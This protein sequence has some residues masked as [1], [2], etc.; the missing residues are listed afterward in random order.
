MSI[1]G[2]QADEKTF[3]EVA[4]TNCPQCDAETVP[5]DRFC[6]D[7]GILLN[8]RHSGNTEPRYFAFLSSLD[9]WYGASKKAIETKSKR[10]WILSLSLSSIAIAVVTYSW[11]ASSTNRN[12]FERAYSAFSK[13]NWNVTITEI[14]KMRLAKNGSLTKA[15]QS[16]LNRALSNR[17]EQYASFGNYRAAMSDLLRVSPEYEQYQ[18]VRDQIDACSHLLFADGTPHHSSSSQGYR[19]R[20]RSVSTPMNY[21][22]L[23]S[24]RASSILKAVSGEE[25]AASSSAK[26][27]QQ[28]AFKEMERR[29]DERRSKQDYKQGKTLEISSQTVVTTDKGMHRYD[30]Q[31]SETSKKRGP[32]DDVARYNELLAGYFS[33]EQPSGKIAKGSLKKLAEVHEPLSF[34]EWISAGKPDF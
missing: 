8:C 5:D 9:K 32:Y 30:E 17:S 15:E 34:K 24:S 1:A 23:S 29:K 19:H 22:L 10:F 27:M 20:H 25:N 18:R 14:E 7:C 26:S 4:Q 33:K 28:I 2:R 11:Q 6:Q 16:L 13:G 3:M 21:P 31:Q 12:L